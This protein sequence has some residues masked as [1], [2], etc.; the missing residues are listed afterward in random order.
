MGRRDLLSAPV[1]L[2]CFLFPV[3]HVF[4]EYDC[5]MSVFVKLLFGRAV[6]DIPPYVDILADLA[7]HSHEWLHD[8]SAVIADIP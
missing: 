5:I 8:N 1:S 2:L 3:Q 7:A 4:L 6:A